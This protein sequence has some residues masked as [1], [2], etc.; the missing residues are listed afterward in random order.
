MDGDWKSKENKEKFFGT[1]N[2]KVNRAPGKNK[3]RWAIMEENKES[4]RAIKHGHSTPL[5]AGELGGLVGARKIVL[6]HFSSRFPPASQTSSNGFEIG[7]ITMNRMI[8]LAE[9]GYIAGQVARREKRKRDGGG[10]G[11]EVMGQDFEV[12]AA[13]DKLRAKLLYSNTIR[14]V[15]SSPA[16]PCTSCD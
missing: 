8:K 1:E 6:N 5:I 10:E 15:T 11:E 9:R 7:R 4:M 2:W 13:E 12:V 3:L 14:V 16:A